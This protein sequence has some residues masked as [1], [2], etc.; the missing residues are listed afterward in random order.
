MSKQHQK[1]LNLFS[2]SSF[3]SQQAHCSENWEKPEDNVSQTGKKSIVRS[4]K[5]FLFKK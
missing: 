5:V 4:K 3:M 1:V 2:I